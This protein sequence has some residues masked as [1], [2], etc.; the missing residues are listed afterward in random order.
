MFTTIV[1]SILR[2]K[3]D[4]S[5]C[6]DLETA[7]SVRRTPTVWTVTYSCEGKGKHNPSLW[8][9]WHCRATWVDRRDRAQKQTGL[10]EEMVNLIV[11]NSSYCQ[12]MARD[13]LPWHLLSGPPDWQA[14]FPTCP[15]SF[16]LAVPCSWCGPLDCLPIYLL[17]PLDLLLTHSW[18]QLIWIPSGS[19]ILH[20]LP[21]SIS[22]VVP[23][24]PYTG[25][26]QDRLGPFLKPLQLC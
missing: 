4:G 26:Q 3:D 1:N 17:I 21:D 16:S 18:L 13:K 12:V 9:N 10:T 2:K 14:A 6:V 15:W 25:L 23:S 5:H 24:G 20:S 8:G 7:S 19:R 11:L 22:A